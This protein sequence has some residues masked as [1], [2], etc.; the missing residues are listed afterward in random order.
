MGMT[1]KGVSRIGKKGLPYL[2][3]L[4][5]LSFL[6][7]RARGLVLRVTMGIQLGTV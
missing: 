5:Y 6:F 4:I 1:V 3:A 2:A 7:T